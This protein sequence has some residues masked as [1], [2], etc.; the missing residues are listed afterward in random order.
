M[1][2]SF[3]MACALTT[4]IS[5]GGCEA[6]ARR[7]FLYAAFKSIDSP[8]EKESPE[9]VKSVGNLFSTEPTENAPIR[10]LFLKYKQKRDIAIGDSSDNTKYTDAEMKAAG[11]VATQLRDQIA[12]KMMILI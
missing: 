12:Y 2:A 1:K 3:F 5:F 11:L 9:P 10:E 7:E 8:L 4:A 6:P